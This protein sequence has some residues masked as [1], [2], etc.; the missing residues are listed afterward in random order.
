MQQKATLNN[1][2]AQE[3]LRGIANLGICNI[4]Y[5]IHPQVQ[6][7]VQTDVPKQVWGTASKGI[8]TR[9]Q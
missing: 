6:V 3:R 5:L 8:T 1:C 9:G 7:L 4:R 2:S